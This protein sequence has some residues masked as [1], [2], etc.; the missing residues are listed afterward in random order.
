M[1]VAV[2]VVALAVVG[3]R[4]V[5]AAGVEAPA[6]DVAPEPAG[7][8]PV[9]VVQPGE[10]LWS[11]AADLQPDGDVRGLVDRLADRSGSGPLQVGQRIP[12]D[13]LVP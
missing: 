4:T 10:T 9:H 5:L 12:L 7:V 11:I 6:G 1:V 13:G 2:V 3:A 8:G